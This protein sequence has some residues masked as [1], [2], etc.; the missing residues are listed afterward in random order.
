[1][2]LRYTA[3]PAKEEEDWL[4]A[5]SSLFSFLTTP[6]PKLVSSSPAGVTATTMKT[7]IGTETTDSAPT[8]ISKSSATAA[9]IGIGAI[10]GVFLVI[11]LFVTLYFIWL[12]KKIYLPSFFYAYFF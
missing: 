6:T 5:N 8:P 10:G 2:K 11:A 3:T 7:P 12:V 4:N 1:M 9:V